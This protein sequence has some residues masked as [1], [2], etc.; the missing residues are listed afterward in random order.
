[1]GLEE[2][3]GARCKG[4]QVRQLWQLGVWAGVAD[5]CEHGCGRDGRG[6]RGRGWRRW[7]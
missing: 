1:M 5:G 7:L 6:V 2:G 4:G 3:V